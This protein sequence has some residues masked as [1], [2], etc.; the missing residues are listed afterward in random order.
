MNAFDSKIDSLGELP[1]LDGYDGLSGSLGS[2]ASVLYGGDIRVVNTPFYQYGAGGLLRDSAEFDAEVL[3]LGEGE[4][5]AGRTGKEEV[6]HFSGAVFFLATGSK[7]GSSGK[8]DC[9][10]FG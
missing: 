10:Y 1:A 8:K 6:L 9:Y 4:G 7:Y 5:P 3:I 2:H